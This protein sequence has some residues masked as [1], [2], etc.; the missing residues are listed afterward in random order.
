MNKHDNMIKE[1]MKDHKFKKAYDE[2]A[3]EFS[4]Y[5]EMLLAR[6]KAGLTQE[7]VAER[8]GTKK[9]AI[10]RLEASGGSHKHSPSVETLRRYAV[11]VGCNLEIKFKH[12]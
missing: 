10:A 5:D 12:C 1:W 6:K 7:E 9:S 11:A 2:L 4:M 3:D 8:M